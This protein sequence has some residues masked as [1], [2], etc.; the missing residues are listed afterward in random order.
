MDRD[1]AVHAVC[2]DKVN[3][4]AKFSDGKTAQFVAA[5]LMASAVFSWWRLQRKD[6]LS[7]EARQSKQ[8]AFSYNSV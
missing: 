7:S 8:T 1:I 6:R 4:R 2:G 3:H 5:F